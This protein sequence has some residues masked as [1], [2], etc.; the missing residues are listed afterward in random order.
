MMARVQP[1]NCA[2]LPPLNDGTPSPDETAAADNPLSIATPGHDVPPH[3]LWVGGLDEMERRCR[4]AINAFPDDLDWETFGPPLVAHAR[5]FLL[6]T[7]RYALHLTGLCQKV[8]DRKRQGLPADRA[9]MAALADHTLTQQ[10]E[11]DM[12]GVDEVL[13]RHFTENSNQTA[14]HVTSDIVRGRSFLQAISICPRLRFV[15]P[16]ETARMVLAGDPTEVC[17]PSCRAG[18][19]SALTYTHTCTPLHAFYI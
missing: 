19:H 9:F 15:H 17:E 16:A 18:L 12:A 7:P 2:R 3:K 14:R 6:S 13:V 10:R 11:A 5:G 4:D 8:V 1:D